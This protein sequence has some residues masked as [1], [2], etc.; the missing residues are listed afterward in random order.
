MAPSVGGAIVACERAR[1]RVFLMETR[2]ALLRCVG[3]RQG[4]A[5]GFDGS[6]LTVVSVPEQNVAAGNAAI[7]LRLRVHYGAVAS[8]A[9][10]RAASTAGRSAVRRMLLLSD[11]GW[12]C[13]FG[14]YH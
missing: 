13:H 14:G 2:P 9:D 8:V 3:T 12:M 1:R 11:L 6:V 10:E 4:D 5:Y 7:A